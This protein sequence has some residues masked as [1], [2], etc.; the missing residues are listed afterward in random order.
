MDQK[1]SAIDGKELYVFY[2][3]LNIPVLVNKFREINRDAVTKGRYLTSEE[4]DKAVEV[5][6]RARAVATRIDGYMRT[7]GHNYAT[8]QKYEGNQIYSFGVYL[9]KEE[10][11]L[12]DLEEELEL[13]YYEKII[14]PVTVWSSF[15]TTEIKHAYVYVMT[16]EQEEKE[17]LI[18]TLHSDDAYL[19][20]C[21]L[22]DLHHLELRG[23]SPKVNSWSFEVRKITSLEKIRTYTYHF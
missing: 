13:R 5:E 17:A 8:I 9:S 12:C 15:T 7:F 20:M 4:L 23:D 6:I 19:Y 11:D 3:L 1:V 16:K 21:M 18:P 10:A 22:T 2:G 14:L